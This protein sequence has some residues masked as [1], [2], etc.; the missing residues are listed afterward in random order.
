MG[1]H[2]Q[3]KGKA[4]ME[5]HELVL[6]GLNDLMNTALQSSRFYTALAAEFATN[7]LTGFGLFFEHEGGERWRAAKKMMDYIIR[8]DS[9]IAINEAPAPPDFSESSPAAAV[10]MAM[11]HEEKVSEHLHALAKLATEHGDHATVMFVGRCMERHLAEHEEMTHLH[12]KLELAG[13]TGPGL[14]SVDRWLRRYAMRAKVR[15][16]K[17]KM[18]EY[19]GNPCKD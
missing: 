12:Q 3:L 16:Y 19:G 17:A 10:K 8:R 14:L 11:E 13:P 5:L 4:T 18:D 2:E 1:H 15:H 9:R 6:D 7:G